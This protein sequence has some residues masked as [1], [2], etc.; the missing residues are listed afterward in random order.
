M[1]TA[2]TRFTLHQLGFLLVQFSISPIV[3]CPLQ[4]SAGV[5]VC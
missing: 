4:T 5:V 3:L 1:L 2:V